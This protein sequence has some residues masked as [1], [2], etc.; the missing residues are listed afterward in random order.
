MELSQY[1]LE[2]LHEDGEFILYRGLR[3]TEAETGPPSIFALSPQME[4]P[5]PATIKKMEHEFSLKGV[6]DP[7]WAIRPIVLTQQQSRTMLL[8]EDTNGNPLDWLL[9]RPM[10]LRQFL[11]CGIALAAALAQVHR[12]GL[13]HK[14][15]KAS[16]V[17]VNAAMDRAWLMGFG[18]AS[19][20]PRERQS[21]EPPELISGTLAYM[22][23]EQTGRMNR[24]ID[25]RSDLYALGITLYELLTGSLPFTA[26]DPTEWVHCHI[27][28]QPLPPADRLRDIPHSVS[29]IIMKL[30]A[31]T[32]E[33]RYQ[34]AAGVESDLRRCLEDGDSVRGARDFTLGE[35]DR[36]DR[37]LISEKLYGREREIETLVAS[38]DRVVKGGAPELVLVSGYSGIGKSSLVNELHKVLPPPRGL[39]A[40]GKFDRYKR[41]IPYSTLA[42]ALRSL[43]RGLLAK[44]ETDLVRWR[45]AIREALGSNGRLMI[46][47]VPELK[48]ILGEQLPV[49]E[50]PPQ[51]AQRR[52]KLLFRRFIGVFA[53]LE[54]PLALLLDDLQWLDSDTL[55]VLEDLLTQADVR[56][57]LMIGVY[58]DNEV[59]ADHLLTRK[60]EGIRKAGVS[61]KEI[62]LAPL[63][64]EDVA[65]LVTDAL[66][67][68]PTRILPLAEL[69]YH[70]TAGN[71][72]FAIQFLSALEHEK[73]LTFDHAHGRWSWDLDRIHA[74]GYTDNVVDLMV[75]KLRR[76]PAETQKALQLLA[77]LGNAARV[78]TLSVV[79]G[80]E[81]PQVHSDLFEAVRAEMVERR[82][83][84]YKFIHDRIQEAAY[85]LMVEQLRPEAHLRI[86][87]MLLVHTPPADREE[88]IL[89]IVNQ[90]NR[91]AALI[92]LEEEREQ[93]AELNLIAA[94]RAKASAAYPS[95]L[96]YL[97][98]GSA[99]L[100]EN[101]WEQRRDLTFALQLNRAECEY[102]TGQ[103]ELAGE[104]LSALATHA[105]TLVERAAV[106]CLRMDL[107][108][109]IDQASLAIVVGRD[110]LRNIGVEWSAHPSKEEMRREYEQISLQ[111]ENTAFEDLINL[112]VLTDS[113]SLAT[114][115]VL[116]RLADIA[117]ATDNNLHVLAICR[118][119][120]FSLERGNCDASCYAY[121]CLGAIA[122]SCFNDYQKGYRFGRIGCELVEQHGWKRLQPRTHLIF[123]AL[124]MPWARPVKAGRDLLRHACEG[125]SSMGDV[126]YA[127]GAGAHVNTN[128]LAAGDHLA[129]VEREVQG[130]LEFALKARFG[131]AI[132]AIATQL[133]LVRTLR[134]LTPRFGCF[135]DEQF[136]E[137]AAERRFASNLNLQG[138]E[139]LYWIRKLQ[140]RFFAGDYTAAIEADSHA[141][142]LVV[143]SP[144]L[145]SAFEAAEYHLYSALCRAACYDSVSPDKRQRYLEAMV[146]HQR[147]LDIWAQN[148][149]ENF[150]NRAAL[151]SAE[152]ACVEGRDL[153][154]M[155]LY[156]KA[157]QSA[158]TNGFIHNEALAYERASAFYRAR[159][160]D[161]F[162]GIY[163]RNARAC[164][165]SWGA[166][167]KVR[168]LDDLFP[169]LAAKHPPTAGGTIE[170]PV[171]HLDL[172]TI[173][174]VSQAVSGE[175]VLQKLID[176][177]MRTAIAH[178]GAER[179][180]LILPLGSD[181][182][183]KAEATT[184]GD[185]IVV[186]LQDAPISSN[187]LPEPIA[188]S[189]VRT[190]ETVILDDASV[191]E[192]P[193]S[194]DPYFLQ[195]ETRSIFCLPLI[196]Q[197][198][199]IGILYL[200]NNLASRV[201]TPSRIGVL[202]V[203]ASQAAISLEKSRLYSDLKVRE[204]KIRRLIEANV[205]GICFWNFDGYI[206]EANDAFLGIVGYN[207]EDL[208]SAPIRWTELSP[209]D[210][211][212]KEAGAIAELIATGRSQPYE[213]ELFRK[214]GRRVPVFGGGALLELG[215]NEGISFVLDLSELK[216]TQTKL[217]KALDEIKQLKDRLQDENVVLR[218][219]VN[220][221][222]MFEE[223]VGASAALNAVLS[224]VSAVAPTDSTVL[225]TGETGTGKEL[226]ARAI[227]KR[228]QR[229]SRAFVSVNC[230][231]IPASL[232]ASELFGHEKGAFTGAL[233]RRPGRFEVAEEGTIFL[234]EVGE[235]PAETQIALLRI[236]QER[237][238]ERVGGNRTL[239]ANVR[240]IAATNRDLEAAIVAGTF[241]S[242]LFYR[243]NVFPI[244]IPPLRERKED[245][246]LLV[247]Y[248]VS[249]FARQAGKSI[250]GINKKTLNLLLSY[251]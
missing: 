170:T 115:N 191:Q 106:A 54:H 81:E 56:H 121:V 169:H 179:G 185:T 213:Q 82:E 74:K 202:R 240:V 182:H 61:I 6:L 55:D 1:R 140:A 86:G 69:I 226:I 157:L 108:L 22:A 139:C 150:E 46:D 241:R 176:T 146:L 133:G 122:G 34:T 5:A 104:R 51:D 36:P 44:S 63:S 90:L 135:D 38:F 37:L 79:Y 193:F 194:A 113:A 11:P 143:T 43:T 248:F 58:R 199:L 68:A 251:P 222:F 128:L 186:R 57:L 211:R 160:F 198:K 137:L 188:H 151:V 227:H 102:V 220:R 114:L 221:A 237:E 72:F 228:S 39:F 87:R 83:D 15:I 14:D 229:S 75:G 100:A 116:T 27:A 17:L 127:V 130:S 30:L 190:E 8:F 31:K 223:I 107:Y 204:A 156:E 189:V 129:D 187:L 219:Q 166:D 88:L 101:S 60:I 208:A 209:P 230:A 124:V 184:C 67:S 165:L 84:S 183:V 155:R 94:Q 177:L 238:F 92:S 42:E 203:L 215:G 112:P 24:S 7:A 232:I 249:R 244:E 234:D 47:L 50:L 142:Q 10:E 85:S 180:L 141:Q 225:L 20:L 242:D 173:I 200:E 77:C 73:L 207:R 71:P 132:Q 26:S 110:Y 65:Q 175:I 147:Q 62:K 23:P 123:G 25:S 134:G 2:R 78:T 70:K 245:I 29:A 3:P 235:V 195:H 218:E 97:V 243:L 161:E 231:A 89:E 181:L 59:D 197:R 167:G 159:G 149:P 148:C 214:D 48:L 247:Q 91:G 45:D 138:A 217:E 168:Q 154:A 144:F 172:A 126:I 174:K 28:R 64:Q 152:I 162:A 239:R 80:T 13:I 9:G 178:A 210:W 52:F 21:A 118:A 66:Q 19:R 206:T 111:L 98:S 109:T 164:Y 117:Y 119:V 192:N 201:F 96:T 99:L 16:N 49:P 95:A 41:D 196:N 33:E 205:I 53:R 93:L 246:P 35:H 212:Y 233:T 236:L 131:I 40:S 153:D 76:L 158:R 125:A 105:A 163:L 18:I 120:N 224:R 4:R 171:E 145:A 216:R 103:L 136:Q 32:P 250:H 12:R